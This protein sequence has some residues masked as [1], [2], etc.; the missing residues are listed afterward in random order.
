[1]LVF[2]GEGKPE[3]PQKTSRCRVENQQTQPT[4]AADQFHGDVL[5]KIAHLN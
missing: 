4:Y 2:E 1:M 5:I 3:Y